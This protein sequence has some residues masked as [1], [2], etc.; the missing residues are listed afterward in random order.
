MNKHYT[1][2]HEWV[3]LD[4][5]VATV[6]ITRHAARQLGEIVE[7][8]F[9]DEGSAIEKGTDFVVVHSTKTAAE[10]FAPVAG[11]VIENNTGLRQNWAAID[12]DPEGAG[13]ICRLRVAPGTEL[14]GLMDAAAY[15]AYLAGL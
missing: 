6:G 9:A 15:D 14:A 3:S 11:E 1:K 5:D 8:D 7:I 4:G 12:T 2:D 10:V 13:W